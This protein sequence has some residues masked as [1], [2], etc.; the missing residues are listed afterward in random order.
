MKNSHQPVVDRTS[1]WCIGGY[2]FTGF[3]RELKRKTVPFRPWVEPDGIQEEPQWG[4][5]SPQC[6]EWFQISGP[7]KSVR[8]FCKNKVP[9]IFVKSLKLAQV[10][11]HPQLIF[12]SKT[13][14]SGIYLNFKRQ[15]SL[16]IQYLPHSESKSYQINSIKSCSSRYLQQHQRHIPIPPKLSATILFNFEWRKHSIFKNFCTASPNIMYQ[17]AH[18]PLLVKS[19]PKT[20]RTRSKHPGLVDLI[21]TKQNKLPSFVDR[22]FS[23]QFQD[24]AKV[25]R[26]I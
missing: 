17:E 15:K 26:T 24:V 10:L 6:K 7:Y 20:P 18:A 21:T 13:W 2:C 23:F 4:V 5:P 19:F 25:V 1:N 22:C 11:P 12:P 14:S 8:Y 3:N 16:K 9:Y